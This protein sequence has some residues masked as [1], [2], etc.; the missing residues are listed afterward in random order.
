MPVNHR[1]F[2][3]TNVPQEKAGLLRPETKTHTNKFAAG[4][5][6]VFMPL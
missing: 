3:E 2:S 6:A 1:E 5:N 4:G